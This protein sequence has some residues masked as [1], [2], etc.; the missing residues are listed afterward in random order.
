MVKYSF[1]FK[2]Q[3]VQ[4]YDSGVGGKRFLAKKYGINRKQVEV[5]K[6]AYKE[7]GA[8][9]LQRKLQNTTYSTQF[10]L[11]AVHLYLTSEESYQEM[12]NE[13]KLNN[14]ALITRWVQDYRK[15]GEFA[16]SKARGRPRKEP[17]LSYN[18]KIKLPKI[19]LNKTE[20]ELARL[21]KENLNLRIE[22][23]Y[24]KGLRRLRLERQAK[25][26]PDLFTPSNENSSSHSK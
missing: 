21:Q 11:N 9:G 23:E 3:V 14:P 18:K 1:D 12:A 16:F 7:F 17:D 8:S 20:Q 6:N 26:N 19:E 24:L 10:K 4:D 22:N 5:W 2:L 25:E 13:L 15:Q